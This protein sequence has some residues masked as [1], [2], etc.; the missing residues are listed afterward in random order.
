ADAAAVERHHGDLEAAVQLAEQRRGGHAAALEV[1]PGGRAAAKAHLVLVA[2]DRQARRA[3]VDEERADAA[4]TALPR[5]RPHHEDARE[6][7][8][9]DPLLAAVEDEL[10]ALAPRGGGHRARIAPG[11]RLAQRE[12]ARAQAAVAEARVVA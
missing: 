11:L 7:A 5:A 9:G 10:V 8:A 6:V 12:R 1:Q 4:G 2:A 3:G